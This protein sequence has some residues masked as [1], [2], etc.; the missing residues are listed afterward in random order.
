[1]AIDDTPL[2]ADGE[3][4]LGIYE[5]GAS[6]G[7]APARVVTVRR[8]YA[9]V[10][11]AGGADVAIDDPD[12][13]VRHAYLHLDER[14]LFGV[15]LATRTGTRFGAS[16]A[17]T[18]WLAPGQ[19][20]EVAGRRLE[21]LELR[22]QGAPLP[23]PALDSD[24]ARS[25]PLADAGDRPLARVTLD[26]AGPG[27][28][29]GGPP[30]TLN[31]ELV[32]VGRSAS[33]G[34]RLEPGAG[35]RIHAVIVRTPAAAFLVDLS[36]R[37]VARN[38]RTIPTASVLDDGDHLEI[39]SARFVVHIEPAALRPRRS[40]LPEPAAAAVLPTL[41]A[42]SI[43]TPAELLPPP[44]PPGLLPAESQTALLAWMM[45]V[46]QATQTEMMRR[47]VDFQREVVGAIR[48][49]HD[50]HQALLAEHLRRVERIQDEL[51]QLRD[52][53]R[54]RLG[55]P[56]ATGVAPSPPL[57][58]L[59]SRTGPSPA[60]QIN[61]EATTAWLLARVSQLDEENRSSWKTLLDRLSGAP[62]QTP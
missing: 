16:G 24:D 9:L 48:T 38:G 57:K 61:P 17:S 54:R 25:S 26:P 39:G 10:G 6:P 20:L 46:L 13:S 50:D 41:A 47:Q 58:P 11:R 29:A 14:G 52:E 3:L 1:M 30:W 2:W 34:I 37:G 60:P 27:P 8:P 5:P 21:V 36:G 7:T 62:R 59:P 45:S 35:A 42:S 19:A 40:G 43:A 23:A 55:S 15:D 33:C 56:P 4:T 12:V 51:A 28:G 18:G 49:I 53:V 31:S 22:L 44:L 32:F